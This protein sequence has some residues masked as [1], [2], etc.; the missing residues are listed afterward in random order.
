MHNPRELTIALASGGTVSARVYEATGPGR[1]TALILAHGAGAGQTSPFMVAT[2]QAFAARGIDTVTF[3]F[4]YIEQQRRAP[5]RR[6]AL[7]ACYR[8]VIEQVRIAVP[9]AT[10]S[11]FIGGKSMGGRIATHV[12]TD[13]QLALAGVVLLG[14]PLHPP[15]RPL[16][17]RDAHLADVAAP[18]LFVQGSRD[19][20]GTPEELEPVVSVIG[21]RAT[22]HV[23][24]GGDHSFKVPRSGTP[25]QAAV[26]A[27]IEQA[28][29]DWITAIQVAPS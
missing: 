25:G 22:L 2:A 27:A 15:G 23:V 24:D 16:D 18:M 17:R 28:I 5:D 20:F 9:T 3:N 8:S 29:D 1:H 12:A 11:L 13:P 10:Q 14:Y 7:E 4:L 19:A 21:S 26:H 6:P